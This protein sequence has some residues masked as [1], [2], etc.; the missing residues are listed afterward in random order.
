MQYNLVVASSLST[1]KKLSPLTGRAIVAKARRSVSNPKSSFAVALPH[2][3]DDFLLEVEGVG[4]LKF[5]LSAQVVKKLIAVSR[6]ATYG[7]KGETKY[8]L[9]VRRSHEIAKSTI[10]LSSHAKKLFLNTLLEEVRQQVGKRGKRFCLSS[11]MINS[12]FILRQ[13]LFTQN[14]WIYKSTLRIRKPD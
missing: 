7:L 13:L 4:R 6:P 11:L 14:S 8:D 1:T 2:P 9:S 12:S 3:S 10:K 5:P